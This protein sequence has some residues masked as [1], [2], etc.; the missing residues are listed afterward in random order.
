MITRLNSLQI[1]NRR[2]PVG[3]SCVSKH[4]DDPAKHPRSDDRYLP[5]LI[6]SIS[7]LDVG[8]DITE[9]D[10]EVIFH[11]RSAVHWGCVATD[12]PC[13]DTVIRIMCQRHDTV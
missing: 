6:L 4:H 11:L 8:D 12:T 7:M 5:E 13:A 2:W 10:V 3:G 1:E 9:V